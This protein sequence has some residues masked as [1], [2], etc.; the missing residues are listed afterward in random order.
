MNVT[1]HADVPMLLAGRMA[2]DHP[3]LLERYE[4]GVRSEARPL[5]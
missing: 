5:R 4:H 2:H 3:R 1:E